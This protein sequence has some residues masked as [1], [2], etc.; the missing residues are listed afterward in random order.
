MNRL[1]RT[2]ILIA[3]ILT[4]AICSA[5]DPDTATA[6]DEYNLIMKS[7]DID[8]KVVWQTGVRLSNLGE[9]RK[10]RELG[11]MLLERANATGDREKCEL[12]GHMLIG[13]V[14]AD[15]SPIKALESL[16]KA[17]AIAESAKNHEALVSIYNALGIYYLINNNDP[18]TAAEYYYN[19]LEEV[20]SLGDDRRYG[21]ILANLS[22]CY[23][24]MN[25]PSGLRLAE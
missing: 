14:T 21:I 13:T 24:V 20:K 7:A 25:D 4:A 5:Q 1:L 8:P 6:I 11:K 17:R 12:Y 22:G 10:A 16:E 2:A 19:G 18:Y 23:Q 3:G 15:S 9:E